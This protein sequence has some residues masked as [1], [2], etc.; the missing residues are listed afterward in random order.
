MPRARCAG[1]NHS[2]RKIEKAFAARKTRGFVLSSSAVRNRAAA[3]AICDGTVRRP[4]YLS[5]LRSKLRNGGRSYG[6]IGA[7]VTAF[8]ADRPKRHFEV[9]SPFRL[10]DSGRVEARK[11]ENRRA[12]CPRN[13]LHPKWN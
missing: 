1:V 13:G 9:E 2:P 10:I 6:D 4:T 7:A 8:L 3:L 12:G 11:V 5:P